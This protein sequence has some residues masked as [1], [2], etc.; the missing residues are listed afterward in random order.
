MSIPVLSAAD[1][2]TI[3]A[4]VYD[5][6]WVE[7][8]VI[9]APDP[10]GEVTARVRLRRFAAVEGRAELEPAAGQWLEVTDVLTNA[11]I[12][13]DLGNVVSALMLYVAKLG[14]E[15]GVVMAATP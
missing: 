6:V 14:R 2:V 7:E 9:S 12:D 13:P 10:N 5:K 8:V 1:P 4:T 11:N 15:H 3:P